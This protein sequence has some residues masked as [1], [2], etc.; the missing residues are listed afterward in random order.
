MKIVLGFSFGDRGEEPGLS[1]EVMAK[2][3][4]RLAPD[5]M[6][7]ISVQWEIGKALRRLY[8]TPNHEVLM[9]RRDGSYLDTDEV[10]SQMINF[11]RASNMRNETIYVVA[12]PAHMSRCIRILRKLGLTGVIPVHADIPYDPKSHQVWTRSP[13]LFRIR[14]I[15]VFPI[16]LFRGHYTA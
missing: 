9:H 3:I 5:I 1:N 4:L 12:H 2:V 7:I 14:E 8:V 16:Y 15:I 10:A 6:D 11:L 13:L